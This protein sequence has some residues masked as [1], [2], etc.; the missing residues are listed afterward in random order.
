MSN[1]PYVISFNDSGPKKAKQ[2]A[3]STAIAASI[4]SVILYVLLFIT[5]ILPS[6]IFCHKRYKKTL[7]VKSKPINR[8]RIIIS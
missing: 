1:S 4:T 2:K 5:H 6:D 3:I 7:P 8:R